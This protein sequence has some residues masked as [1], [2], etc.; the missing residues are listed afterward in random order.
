MLQQ[1]INK[2]LQL[3]T[4]N[5]AGLTIS[6]AEV[7][8]AIKRIAA[9]NNVSVEELYKH[10]EQTGM[11]AANY[12]NEIHDQVLMQRLQQHE[13]AGKVTV[14]QE[15]ITAFM[16]ANPAKDS[17]ISEYRLQDILIPLSDSPSAAELA[18]AKNTR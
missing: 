4:A 11:T 3:Q 17:G 6:D 2:K 16:K 13:V 1:L 7:D 18:A 10:I 9:Q 15:E 12:R 5:Q 14:T 8:D